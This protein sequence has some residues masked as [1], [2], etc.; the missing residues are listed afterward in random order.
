MSTP[1]PDQHVP[2]TMEDE[3][4]DWF[5]DQHYHGLASDSY[6]AEKLRYASAKHVHVTSRRYFI[7]PIPKGWLQHHRKSWFKTRGKFKKQKAPTF[8]A[9][10]GLMTRQDGSDQPRPGYSTGTGDFPSPE[11]SSEDDE[12]ERED[13]HG[14][15]TPPSGPSGDLR[16]IASVEETDSDP[17]TVAGPESSTVQDQPGDQGQP[18][19]TRRDSESY[20]TAREP[21][22]SQGKTRVSTLQRSSGTDL[23]PSP[24]EESSQY[25]ASQSTPVINTS[26]T[27]ITP[28]LSRPPPFKGKGKA[29]DSYPTPPIVTE[30]GETADGTDPNAP[31]ASSRR[32]TVYNTAIWLA[33][34]AS[35]TGIDDNLWSKKERARSRISRTQD[36]VADLPHRRRNKGGEIIKAE[37]M[38]VRVEESPRDLPDD[39][40]EN[41]SQRMETRVVDRWR[42]YLVVC[43]RSSDPSA[44]FC[45]QMYKTRVIPD[46]QRKGAR[47]SPYHEVL[48]DRKTVSVNLYSSLDKTIVIWRPSKYG[49]KIFIVRPK[50]SAHA[51]EWST[52]LRQALGWRRPSSLEINVPDLGVSLIFQHPFEQ[53]DVGAHANPSDDEDRVLTR[54]A[55]RERFA[56][57]SIIRGCM[58]MLSKESEWADVLKQWSKTEKMGLAWKRYDR[59]EWVFGINEQKMYGTMAMQTSHE[60]ELR[61]RQHYRTHVIADDGR[62]D[63]PEPV[64]GFLIRLTSQRGVHQRRNKMFYKRLYFFCQDHYLFF[65]RPT[66]A[67]PPPPPRICEHESNI[68]STQDILSGSPLCYSVDPYPLHNGGVEWLSSGNAEHIKRHDTEAVVQLRRNLHNLSRSD[69]FIDLRQVEEV[70]PVQRDS[71]PAD[72]NIGSGPDVAFHPDAQDSRRDDGDT[73]QFDDDRT[74]ELRLDNGLVV[75]LQTYN[76]ATK[77]EWITRLDALVRYWK[78]RS[79]ADSTELKSIRQRNLELLGIDEELE[80]MLGQYAC[81]WEV[82]KALASP[83]LHNMCSLA[84]CRAIKLS[85][86][87]YRKPRRHSTFKQCDVVLTDGKL[88]IFRSALRKR[89]G[90]NV[91]HT[92]THLDTTLDLNDCYIYSGILTEDD[93]LYANQTFDSNHPGQHHALPRVYLSTDMYTSS[94]EDTAI[95]FVVWQPLRKN[96]FRAHEL[97]Q[98]GQKRQTLKQVSRLGVH[99][100]TAVFKARSRLDKD[101]WVLSIASEIDRLQEEKPEDIRVV[102]PSVRRGVS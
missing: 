38:L 24:A 19:I 68:P 89:N 14:P 59:L 77:D 79:A 27:S 32:G 99:G 72:P 17:T 84:G 43:R 35:R 44:R 11:T 101:R 67:L 33:Q 12:T 81:K 36:A 34:K 100:R 102:T 61:P 4:Q 83:L 28:L 69:G 2:D 96:L 74:F 7:G 39:Y 71:C 1:P 60:L 26:E 66:R 97:G 21:P 88:L 63:E 62:Q 49:S 31:G 64:E 55:A 10:T 95:T 41:Y 78:L 82:K 58:E 9:D 54:S 80:S 87:L 91:P 46:I 5:H 37:N 50:S 51:A 47:I 22:P 8:S 57:A 45:I 76:E 3:T 23:G 73:R 18:E 93:L 86:Q 15:A 6:S 40:T 29:T 20:Y 56:A 75:R 52:F 42:E 70:R 85:G 30:P 98:E 90:V 25:E 94:D 65:C 16:M 92:H 53:I 48:L 13:D